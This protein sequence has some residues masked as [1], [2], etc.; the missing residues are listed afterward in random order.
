MNKSHE[1][2]HAKRVFGLDLIRTAAILLVIVH[3]GFVIFSFPF[4]PLPDGVDIFFVL[5]GF[6]IGRILIKSIVAKPEFSLYDLRLFLLRRWFRTLPALIVILLINYAITFC[7]T[8][9]HTTFQETIKQMLIR[10]R[11][12]QYFFFVQNLFSNLSTSFFPESWS[13]SV[14]EW[15]YLIMP[16]CLFILLKLKISARQAT[17]TSILILI[18]GPSLARYFLSD[19]DQSGTFMVTRMVVMMRLDSIGFGVLLA[20]ISFYWPVFWNRLTVSRF[21]I[22][23]GVLFFYLAFLVVNQGK[24]FFNSVTLTNFFFFPLSSVAVM[25]II[26]ALSIPGKVNNGFRN[27]VTFISKISYSMYLINFSIIIQLIQV[28]SPAKTTQTEN[29]I[30][31]L[32]YWIATIGISALMYR[33]VEKPFLVLRDRYFSE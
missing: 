11:L 20:Y 10:D 12:W 2:A 27:V 17:F 24:L 30:F 14:E 31:Y 1:Q 4:I 15:F 25:A 26:P 8:L 6:L 22:V 13:L 21:L 19:I 28:F 9:Q 5:S 3:H 32:I 33:Y 7:L 23:L 29:F 16:V 18:I